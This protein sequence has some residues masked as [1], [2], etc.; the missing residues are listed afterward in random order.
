MMTTITMK[1]RKTAFCAM[2]VCFAA[3]LAVMETWLPPLTPIPGV[4]IGLGNTVILFLLYL[5][6]R[7][8]IKDVL[9]VALLKCF[10]AA[11]ITG[12]IMG[13]CYG[14]SG[15]LFAFGAMTVAKRL[16]PPDYKYIPFAGVAGA[17]FHIIGQLLTALIFY[18]TF[19]VLVYLPI[20]IVSA[21]TGGAFTG[22]CA[23]LLIK[24]MG[25]D[26]LNKIRLID[27]S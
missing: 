13:L 2:F 26:L 16:L 23:M 5:G 18:G 17:I 20:L 27:V 1:I 21:I 6:G 22:I 3:A 19:S 25:K 8:N 10:L 24:K 4:R 11:L 12:N 15:G 7:W 9:T 14:V